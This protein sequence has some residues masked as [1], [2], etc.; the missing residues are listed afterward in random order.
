MA[1]MRLIECRLR[2]GRHTPSRH[3]P[4]LHTPGLMVPAVLVTV[5]LSLSCVGHGVPA[6]APDPFSGKR[7]EPLDVEVHVLHTGNR[8]HDIQDAVPDPPRGKNRS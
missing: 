4:G 7:I 8:L 6:V 3:T 1:L 2:P 5:A